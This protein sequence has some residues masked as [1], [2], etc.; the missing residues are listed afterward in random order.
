MVEQQLAKPQDKT[1]SNGIT[2][3]VIRLLK[4]VR[5]LEHENASLRRE[6]AAARPLAA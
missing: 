2:D 5:R 6:L 1:F 4:L 3:E